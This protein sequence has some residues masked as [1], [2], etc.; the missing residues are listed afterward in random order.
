MYFFFFCFFFSWFEIQQIWLDSLSL[1]FNSKPLNFTS[2]GLSQKAHYSIFPMW[3]HSF[4]CALWT[5]TYLLA[6][7]L[8]QPNQVPTAFFFFFAAEPTTNHQGLFQRCQHN[9]SPS[10]QHRN[11]MWSWFQQMFQCFHYSH[12]LL[13]SPI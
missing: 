9:H 12:H 4:S 3:M 1:K 5:L 8:H 2:T 11:D 6:F 7:T 13:L 10:N